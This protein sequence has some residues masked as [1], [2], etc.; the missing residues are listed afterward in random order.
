MKIIY[1]PPGIPVPVPGKVDVPLYP[2]QTPWPQSRSHIYMESRIERELALFTYFKLA[3]S[4]FEYQTVYA[5]SGKNVLFRIS[6]FFRVNI[7]L[8]ITIFFGK[9]HFKT[10]I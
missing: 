10:S 4:V 9:N 8:G 1:V 6:I 3:G 2:F 5:F 7:F